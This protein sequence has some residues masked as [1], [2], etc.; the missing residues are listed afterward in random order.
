MASSTFNIRPTKSTRSI[1][2]GLLFATIFLIFLQPANSAPSCSGNSNNGEVSDQTCVNGV[3]LDWCHQQVCG[4]GPGE[5]CGGRWL[6]NGACG[7]NMFCACGVCNGCNRL[8]Q[9]YS[10]LKC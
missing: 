2:C 10:N 7:E 4:K 8:L 9:C 1:L 3:V 6:E 5:P